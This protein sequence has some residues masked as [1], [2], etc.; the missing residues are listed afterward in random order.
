MW[1]TD[2]GSHQHCP[3]RGDPTKSPVP[4]H[5]SIHDSSH[6]TTTT[7]I[8]NVLVFLQWLASGHG[9]SDP[10]SL[11]WQAVWKIDRR[12]FKSTAP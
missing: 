5:S 12:A 8:P 7:R 2:Q 9:I 3:E 10:S 1:T 4:G 11:S 6:E